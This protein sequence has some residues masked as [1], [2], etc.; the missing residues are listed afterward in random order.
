[1]NR[2]MDRQD[3]ES[4]RDIIVV[5]LCEMLQTLVGVVAL[6]KE[7]KEALSDLVKRMWGLREG[8]VTRW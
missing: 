8:A 3:Q 4:K 5:V 6:E 1:M 7:K 2:Q